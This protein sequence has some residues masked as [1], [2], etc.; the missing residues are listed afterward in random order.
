[1]IYQAQNGETVWEL[2]ERFY[3]EGKYYPLVMELNPQ[4]LQGSVK[5]GGTAMAGHIHAIS[6]AQHVFGNGVVSVEAMGKNET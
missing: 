1:M 4:I 5:G 6:L 2:A 3:G